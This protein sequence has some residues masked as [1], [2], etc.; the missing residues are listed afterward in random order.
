M[1]IGLSKAVPLGSKK[2]QKYFVF[3][4]FFEPSINSIFGHLFHR[5]SNDTA[6][7]VA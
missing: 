5:I 7:S 3:L 2:F 6:P 4:T 1:S